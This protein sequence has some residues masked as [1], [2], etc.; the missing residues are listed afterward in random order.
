MLLTFVYM[1]RT[2]A[3]ATAAATTTT[4]TPSNAAAAAA[5]TTT[6]N[7]TLSFSHP[8]YTNPNSVQGVSGYSE[9][10]QMASNLD[11]QHATPQDPQNSNT[12]KKERKPKQYPV[13]TATE[14][15]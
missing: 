11:L 4:T 5:I 3:T 14:G 7:S 1:Q 10:N 2:S 15:S 6:T 12:G 8:P 13:N 9:R